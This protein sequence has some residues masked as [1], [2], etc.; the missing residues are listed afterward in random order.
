MVVRSRTEKPGR[1]F[2][3]QGNVAGDAVIT[4]ERDDY[5][6]VIAPRDEPS[7]RTVQSTT[8]LLTQG[9]FPRD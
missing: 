6:V 9:L 7:Q 3:M 1:Q 4:A 5:V 8:A 2:E